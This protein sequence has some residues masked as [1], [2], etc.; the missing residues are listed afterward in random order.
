MRGGWE[1]ASLSDVPRTSTS[2]IKNQRRNVPLTS[3]NFE[4]WM[5]ELA[6][7]LLPGGQDGIVH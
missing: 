5:R 1:R 4:S 2:G 7:G 3:L 6:L